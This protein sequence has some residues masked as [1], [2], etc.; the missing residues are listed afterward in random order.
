VG[1][2]ERIK[3]VVGIPRRRWKSLSGVWIAAQLGAGQRG[4]GFS[5]FTLATNS[6]RSSRLKLG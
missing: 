1:F 6:L 4:D 5:S 3:P 2:S